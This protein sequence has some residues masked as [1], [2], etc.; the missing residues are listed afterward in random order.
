MAAKKFRILSID[1]GGIRGVYPAHIIHRMSESFGITP[2]THF[3]M[4]AGTSTGSIIAAGIACGVTPEKIVSLYQKKG[5]EIFC[6]KWS[7]ILGALAPIFHSKYSNEGLSEA[8]KDIFGDITL[9]EISLPL[10]LPSTDIGNG[11]V[12]V[13]KSAYSPDFTRDNSVLVRDAVL[14][15]CSAPTYFDPHRVGK[16]AL[17]DGGLWANNPSLAA[18]IDAQKRL[19]VDLTDIS[20]FSLGTGLA[21][22]NY[23]VD[24]NRRWNPFGG[25][26]LLKHLP[27]FI[28]WRW[29]FATGWR[30]SDLLDFIMS[31]QGQSIHNYLQ[32]LLREE[33]MLRLTFESNT[34]L[35]LDDCAAIEDLISRADHEF[36]HKSEKIGKFLNS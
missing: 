35:P 21:K 8:L 2:S 36:T 34:P 33:Q 14:A 22:T 28:K 3:Q 4:I 20:V 15:S 26:P 18:V 1:G 13:F 31:V 16:Y 10:L 29:G 23:S 17:V 19:G 11:G 32:L 12:H 9:G 30:T 24:L 5:K 25:I 6:S 7:S 27:G